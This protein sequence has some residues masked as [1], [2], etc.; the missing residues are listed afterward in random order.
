VKKSSRSSQQSS[1]QPTG[2]RAPWRRTVLI[3]LQDGAP[4]AFP[5]P[6][7]IKGGGELRFEMAGGPG[8]ALEFERSPVESGKRAFESKPGYGL[9]RRNLTVVAPGD[10]MRLKYSI[11][12]DGVTTDP[13]I[14]IEPT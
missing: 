8:F 3:Y 1:T 6:A 12:V 13:E 2:V 11:T 10:T 14:I 4:A 7:T 5:D 9:R